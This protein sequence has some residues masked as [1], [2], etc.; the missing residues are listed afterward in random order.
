VLAARRKP[1]EENVMA[2]RFL[3]RLQQA[4]PRDDYKHAIGRALA[5]VSTS[6]S[7]ADRG[8]MVG[9]LLLAIEETKSLR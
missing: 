7:I 5:V 3:A 1:F 6:A 4:A 2:I 8:R 9:D